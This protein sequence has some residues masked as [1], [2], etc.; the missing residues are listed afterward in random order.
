MG[1]CLEVNKI[2]YFSFSL[3]MFIEFRRRDFEGHKQ[4]DGDFRSLEI[5]E[6]NEKLFDLVPNIII[7][8]KRTT[9]IIYFL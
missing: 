8:K 6:Q 7:H 1:F 4:M 9:E 5:F 2:P 3:V